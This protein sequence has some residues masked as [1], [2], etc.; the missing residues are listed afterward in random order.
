MYQSLIDSEDH[1]IEGTSGTYYPMVLPDAE[2][3]AFFRG[4]QL[5]RVSIQGGEALPILDVAQ[6]RTSGH[7]V[8]IDRIFVH[9]QYDRIRIVNLA[10]REVTV[11]SAATPFRG[12]EP[13]GG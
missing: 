6:G 9:D 1:A 8:S 7:W 3:V 13:T 4:V 5:R 10:T 2:W 11:R 12:P